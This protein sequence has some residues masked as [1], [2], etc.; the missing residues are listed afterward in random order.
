MNLERLEKLIGGDRQT[1]KGCNLSADEA[2][3]VAHGKF[4]QHSFCLVQDWTILDLETTDEELNVLRS[5]GLKPVLIY[6]LHV[7]HDSRGRFSTG[8]WVRSSFQQSYDDD[9]FFLTKNTVYV[10]LGDGNR[11]QI[12]AR[13]FLSLQ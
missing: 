1:V 10:L 9:G 3:A 6:A 13:D 7:V 2:A 12:T 11:Q 4:A 8:D 5:R